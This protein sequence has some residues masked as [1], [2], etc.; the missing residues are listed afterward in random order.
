MID[1]ELDGIERA[2]HNQPLHESA[3]YVVDI[4]FVGIVCNGQLLLIANQRGLMHQ[5]ER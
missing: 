4:M 1:H 5:M 3:E 2:F